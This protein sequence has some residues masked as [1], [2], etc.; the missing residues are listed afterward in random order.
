MYNM[1]LAAAVP[2]WECAANATSL[3]SNVDNTSEA[4][5]SNL[6]VVKTCIVGGQPCEQFEFDTYMKTMASEVGIWLFSYWVLDW[7]G[8]L[9]R[10]EKKRKKKKK[11]NSLQTDSNCFNL[12]RV[13]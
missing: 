1:V 7:Y 3:D 9:N 2:H 10:K 11:T 8:K 5:G 4:T 6:S 13:L 12:G